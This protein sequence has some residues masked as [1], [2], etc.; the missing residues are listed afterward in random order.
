[1]LHLNRKF[2]K[3]D[4]HPLPS[5]GAFRLL[6]EATFKHKKRRLQNENCNRRPKSFA[7]SAKA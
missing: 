7:S 4:S 5:K 3:N 1:M 2:H 6:E